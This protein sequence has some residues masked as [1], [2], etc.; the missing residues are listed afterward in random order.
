LGEIGIDSFHLQ[1]LFLPFQ[2]VRTL[3][4]SSLRESLQRGV[5]LQGVARIVLVEKV[6]TSIQLVL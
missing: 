2:A 4:V 3:G 5:T 6:A 1:Q